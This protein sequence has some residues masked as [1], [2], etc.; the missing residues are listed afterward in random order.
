MASLWTRLIK[1]LPSLRPAA[2]KPIGY[3]LQGNK[4]FEL[5]NPE[6]GRPKRIVEY[7]RTRVR[8]ADYTEGTQQLPGLSFTRS[9]P[10]P[11]SELQADDARLAR[12]APLVA[13][14]DA[15]ERAERFAQGYLLADGSAPV[16]SGS[17]L[18]AAP[19]VVEPSFEPPATE[20]AAATTR[21]SIDHATGE[22]TGAPAGLVGAGA[23]EGEAGRAGHA[24]Q[25]RAEQPRN[26]GEYA[27]PTPNGFGSPAPVDPN[28]SPEELRRAAEEDTRRR[29]GARPGAGAGAGARAG[30]EAAQGG[31]A[32]AGAQ[33][34][35]VGE[36]AVKPRRRGGR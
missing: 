30:A 29:A 10:P 18:L 16:A 22:V 11:L 32:R 26:N 4:Y 5:P 20:P 35:Q 6:G 33:R 12:L 15:R 31:A 21:P 1:A 13:Q 7:A 23:A 24:W 34:D 14:I 9:S 2:R 28:A 27:V 25:A 8:I 19:A 17:G 36:A 3:D